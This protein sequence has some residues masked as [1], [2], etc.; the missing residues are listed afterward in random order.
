MANVSPAE[1]QAVDHLRKAIKRDAWRLMQ[2]AEICL[3]LAGLDGA[4]SSFRQ[5]IEDSITDARTL[6]EA[7]G[8]QPV[9]DA[10]VRA[11]IEREVQAFIRTHKHTDG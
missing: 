2:D 8:V 4:I 7:A 6:A 1:A 10:H 9:T 3:T 5:R 11:A